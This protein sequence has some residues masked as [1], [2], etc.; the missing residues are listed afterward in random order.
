[1]QPRCPLWFGTKGCS[2]YVLHVVCFYAPDLIGLL[3]TAQ[4]T[5]EFIVNRNIRI[6][7]DG[8]WLQCNS[9][10]GHS[11]RRLVLWRWWWKQK[12]GY[13]SQPGAAHPVQSPNTK[14]FTRHKTKTQPCLSFPHPLPPQCSTF[15]VCFISPSSLLALSHL[16]LPVE[17]SG[18]NDMPAL[19]ALLFCILTTVTTGTADCCQSAVKWLRSVPPSTVLGNTWLSDKV[20]MTF[21]MLD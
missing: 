20:Q 6:I 1:M 4:D 5:G 15:F 9:L 16:T 18:V 8:G 14:R 2:L 12:R 19:C 21:T 3:F 11:S 7:S 10:K 17:S 13:Q